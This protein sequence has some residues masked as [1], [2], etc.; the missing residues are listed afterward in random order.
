MFN[1]ASA[2]AL[3]AAVALTV[4][5]SAFAASLPLSLSTTAPVTPYAAVT[6]GSGVTTDA[7]LGGSFDYGNS[8]NNS[9]PNT[10]YMP[11]SGTYAGVNFDFYDDYKFTI[12]GS[13]VNAV[14]STISFANI[15]AIDNL[16]ARLY[17]VAGNAVPTLGA[18]ATGTLIQAWG[19]TNTAFPGGM[20]S[21][22]VLNNVSLSAGTYVLELRGTVTG[23][24]GGSYAGVLNVAPVPVPSALWLMGSAIVGL[25]TVGR[26]RSH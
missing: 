15:F 6:T 22:S 23:T 25:G 2:R 16:H 19:T 12:T 8:F 4:G 9:L 24:N 17:N 3:V 11:A 14:S 20:L 1:T 7:T 18:L 13:T 5:G 10:L 26:K 21:Y